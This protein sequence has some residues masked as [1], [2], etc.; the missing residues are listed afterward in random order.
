MYVCVCLVL[1][2][3]ARACVCVCVCVCVR[4]IPGVL[5]HAH[6]RVEDVDGDRHLDV[7]RKW[8]VSGEDALLGRR[9]LLHVGILV[10]AKRTEPQS[11]AN[12]M[13]PNSNSWFS[14]FSKTTVCGTHTTPTPIQ[15][16]DAH[17]CTE[18]TSSHGRTHTTTR[19]PP[20][21]T[22]KWKHTHPNARTHTT[23]HAHTCTVQL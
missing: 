2:A 8:N 1:C 23:T 15:N 9:H 14:K 6:D 18:H 11:S 21:H 20:S 7:D 16:T 5:T 3:R 4:T 17:I 10:A 19:T 13:T 22:C 12:A